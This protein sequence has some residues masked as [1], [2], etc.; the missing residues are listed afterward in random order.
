MNIHNREIATPKVT[1]GPI[2]GSK[3]IYS[4]PA[5]AVDLRVPL[6]ETALSESAK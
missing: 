3:K 6:K 4:T 1:T 5:A 2:T